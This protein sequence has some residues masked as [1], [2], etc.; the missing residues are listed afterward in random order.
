MRCRCLHQVH[1]CRR[2]HH[3]TGH[4]T[5][6]SVSHAVGT[7]QLGCPLNECGLGPFWGMRRGYRAASLGL[8]FIFPPAGPA[9]K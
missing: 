7:Q 1:D 9:A 3:D 8:R 5:K 2:G 4:V 6:E